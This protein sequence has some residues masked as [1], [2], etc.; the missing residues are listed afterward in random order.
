MGALV[1][2]LLCLWGV[3]SLKRLLGADDA[4][5]VFGVHGL[6]GLVSVSPDGDSTAHPILKTSSTV[7]PPGDC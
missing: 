4:L 2:G 1:I 3:N 5:D 7:K 6:G